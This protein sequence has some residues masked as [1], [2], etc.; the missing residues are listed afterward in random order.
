MTSVD[1]DSIFNGLTVDRNFNLKM[2]CGLFFAILAIKTRIFDAE[3][4]G[5]RGLLIMKD[6]CRLV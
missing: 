4:C 5:P 3:R 1:S 2:D 6:R